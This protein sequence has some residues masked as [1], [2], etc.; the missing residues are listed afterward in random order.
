MFCVLEARLNEKGE[1]QDAV[2]CRRLA[3]RVTAV[4]QKQ[5]PAVLEH[6]IQ[7]II[8]ERETNCDAKDV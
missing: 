3:E 8:A 1:Q 2:K 4:F 5:L 7:Q 6:G